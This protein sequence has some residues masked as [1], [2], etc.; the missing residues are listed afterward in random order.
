MTVAESKR[1]LS[2]WLQAYLD[3]T[4]DH[5]SPEKLHMWTALV[6]LSAAVRRRIYMN[7]VGY[8]L[9]P[10]LYVLTVAESAKIRKSAAIDPG[11]KLLREAIPGVQVFS[12]RAT[13]EGIVKHL[14]RQ[15]ITKD[16]NTGKA[17]ITQD[18]HFVIHADELA[19]LFTYDKRRASDMAVLLTEAYNCKDIHDHL[20]S[21]EGYQQIFNLYGCMI[22]ATDPRNL[23]V[24]PEEA[25][26]GLL[27]RTI[28]V[29]AN[30]IRRPI[31]WGVEGSFPVELRNKLLA[32]L[33]TIGELQGVIVPTPEARDEFERWYIV[34]Q[35]VQ[36]D[37]PRL[38][39]F[40]ARCHDTALKI[41]MLLAL[42]RSN[43]LV[44]DVGHMKAGIAFIE[45]LLPEYSRASLWTGT[46]IHIQ[47][48][49]T[50]ID[51]IRKCGGTA[52]RRDVLRIM[53]VT[54]EELKVLEETLEAEG[55]LEIK[56]L[57]KA[58]IYRLLGD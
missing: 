50:F 29:T 47:N 39:A 45:T 51:I 33:T 41:A 57:G 6:M 44:L 5:E 32:D 4:K 10:N 18:S 2:D 43:N 30:Q 16:A 21:G 48:R 49:A 46:T 15:T 27:G 37:D 24:L 28:I 34:Q 35:S 40:H 3:Y 53:R 8:R 38:S 31:A 23:K 14:N 17:T 55:T 20:T 42:S 36:H 1:Q 7:R 26:G 13:P 9:Y 11:I 56:V 58:M 19:T 54:L 25:V 22:A 12:G 52:P